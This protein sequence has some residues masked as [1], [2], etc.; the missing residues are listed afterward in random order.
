M[1]KVKITKIHKRDAWYD[2][3]DEVL[4]LV[5]YATGIYETGH[6]LYSFDFKWN[7]LSI[8]FMYAEFEAIR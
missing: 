6:N 4:G 5:G 2:N 1:T 3:R 8:N 7:G